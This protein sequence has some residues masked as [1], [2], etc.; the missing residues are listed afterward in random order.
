MTN[1]VKSEEKSNEAGSVVTSLL[2]FVPSMYY[3]VIARICPGAVFWIALLQKNNFINSADELIN[4][5]APVFFMLIFLGY[6]VGTVVTGFGFLWDLILFSILSLSGQTRGLLNVENFSKMNLSDKWKLVFERIDKIGQK[7]ELAE[8]TLIKAL[9]EVALCQNLLSELIIL[10][11]IGVFTNGHA[12]YSLLDYPG[13]YII[14]L[15]TLLAAMIFRQIVFLGR[16][17]NM[18]RIY[19]IH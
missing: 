12:F 1:E 3:D 13:Y 5:A 15:T 11:V 6:V 4:F 9:A 10:T 14:V 16:V 7:N 17:N 8:R 19:V 18:Y 2:N